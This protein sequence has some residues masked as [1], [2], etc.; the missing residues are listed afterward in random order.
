M[1]SRSLEV[2]ASILLGLSLVIVL[3]IYPVVPAN[4]ASPDSRSDQR[5]VTGCLA[6]RAPK[7]EFVL[8]TTHDDVYILQVDGKRLDLD[9][10]VGHTVKITGSI[11]PNAQNKSTATSGTVEHGVVPEPPEMKVNSVRNVSSTCG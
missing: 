10:L 7:G 1:N 3:A 6:K 5:T 2:F 11:V 4:A 9:H 8:T